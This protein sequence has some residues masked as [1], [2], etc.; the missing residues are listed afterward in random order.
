MPWLSKSLEYDH[1]RV[2]L[3]CPQDVPQ[4]LSTIAKVS[5]KTEPDLLPGNENQDEVVNWLMKSPKP[6]PPGSGK[7]LMS[8]LTNHG[9]IPTPLPGNLDERIEEHLSP[10]LKIS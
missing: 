4:R 5:R 6:C 10:G 2:P 1:H 9:E 7:M 3:C 8:S